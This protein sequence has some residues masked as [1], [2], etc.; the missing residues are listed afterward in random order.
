MCNFFLCSALYHVSLV[1]SKLTLLEILD[2]TNFNLSGSE[3]CVDF[4]YKKMFDKDP[5]EMTEV[6]HYLY[7]LLGYNLELVDSQKFSFV[8][9]LLYFK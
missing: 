6:F 4:L 1:S 8:L 9:Y 5:H 3:C 7:I 2:K